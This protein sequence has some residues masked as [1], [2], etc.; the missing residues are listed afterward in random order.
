M[1]YAGSPHGTWPAVPPRHRIN[2]R[3]IHAGSAHEDSKCIFLIVACDEEYS[4]NG[5]KR[6]RIIKGLCRKRYRLTMS[7]RSN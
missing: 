6:H 4:G 7:L 5:V 3:A 1:E 2:F